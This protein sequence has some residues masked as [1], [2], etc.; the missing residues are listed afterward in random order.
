MHKKEEIKIF[1][2]YEMDQG[3]I[4]L[5]RK[6]IHH[7]LYKEKRYFS[8]F[9]AWIDLLLMVNHRDNSFM[10]GNEMME[11]K[12]GSKITSIKY[13]AERWEWS[14]KKVKNFLDMLQNDGMITYKSTS[15]YTYISIENYTKY[16][17]INREEEHEKH[18]K[19]TSKEHQRNTNNNDN[20]VNNE[21]KN[22]IPEYSIEFEEFW[23]VYPKKVE[24]QKA[25]K[26]YKK[27]LKEGYT[28]LQLL[29]AASL[30]AQ[31]IKRENTD[32]KYIK[33]CSTFL[34]PN[35][36]FIEY[37]EGGGNHGSADE[38]NRKKAQYDKSKWL[39]NG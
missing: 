5:Y 25:F 12:R 23:K 35:K 28:S 11:V 17:G 3:W 16:Q 39:Y 19:G 36:P 22:K 38:E 8:K 30:Y 37:L 6:I 34:G 21:N 32:A 1:G 9:E 20:N 14:R 7:P 31:Q 33:H 29:K 26:C 18:I 2:G 15:K 10:M 13:L 4:S 27:L 24:K